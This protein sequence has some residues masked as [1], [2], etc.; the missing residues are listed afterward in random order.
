MPVLQR[1]DRQT[2]ANDSVILLQRRLNDYGYHI[3]DDGFF[4]PK[5][6]AAVRDF[7]AK[8]HSMS[9]DFLVDGIVG[10][11]TWKALGTCV[12]YAEGC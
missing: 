9:P 2:V 11:Q 4:G 6:E 5:T 12:I 10:V 3:A 7:Q 1:N 8:Q